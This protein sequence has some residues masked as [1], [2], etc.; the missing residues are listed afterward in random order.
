MKILADENIP[1]VVQAFSPL[2]EVRTIP[3]RLIAPEHIREVDVLLVRTVTRVD[4]ALLDGSP[5]RFVGTATSGFD[6]IDA[7]CLKR[8][9]VGFAGA[10]GANARSVAEYVI[11]AIA[12]LGQRF[13]LQAS[14]LSLGIVGHGH[15]GKRVHAMASAL[16]MR[17]VVNDPPLARTT[18]ESLYRP[19]NEVLDCDIVTLH[20]PLEHGGADPTHHLANEAFLAQ[21]KKGAILINTSR[22]GVIDEAALKPK[23][24]DGS[25]KACVLDVWENEPLPDP[26]LIELAAIATPHIAGYSL[27]SRAQG[28]R[29]VLER[30]CAHLGL[31]AN[32]DPGPLLPAPSTPRIQVDPSNEGALLRAIREIYDIM[33][34]DRKM[35]ALT[36]LDETAR[37]TAFDHLRRDYP[38]RREF[39]S[40]AAQVLG[41]NEAAEG[42]LRALGFQVAREGAG[43]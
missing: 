43:P 35:R 27:D 36:H 22:G 23:L 3:G 9:G 32:W 29:V 21:M 37:G 18:G 33:P 10:A 1:F 38:P 25:L 13:G 26:E 8:R 24:R 17:C 34:E 14:R 39:S 2:G 12:E 4:D 19:L 11:A 15:V 20:V 7:E 16:G 6:H 41:A 42:A 30:A 28:T 40:T 5:V 31:E